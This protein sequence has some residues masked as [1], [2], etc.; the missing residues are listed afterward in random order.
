M[1][2]LGTIR[3]LAAK[4]AFARD[5]LAFVETALAGEFA[6]IRE[7][8]RDLTDLWFGLQAKRMAATGRPLGCRVTRRNQTNLPAPRVH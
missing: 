1:Q 6:S 3:L 7:G 2:A 8:A 5:D 4:V